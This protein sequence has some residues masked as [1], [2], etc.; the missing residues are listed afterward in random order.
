VVK[1]NFITVSYHLEKILPVALLVL[2]QLWLQKRL[3]NIVIRQRVHCARVT[4]LSHSLCGSVDA[5]RL[6]KAT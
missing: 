2:L 6:V 3:V 5:A 4:L 1:R